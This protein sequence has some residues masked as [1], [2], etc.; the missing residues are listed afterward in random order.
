M[1]KRHFTLLELMAAMVVL[2]IMMGFLFHFITRSQQ[3][4]NASD[5][6]ARIYENA[7]I[8]FDLLGRDLTGA[9]V[10]KDAERTISFWVGDLGTADVQQNKEDFLAFATMSAGGDGSRGANLWEIHYRWGDNSSGVPK[11][12]RCR[13]WRAAVNSSDTTNWD[14]YG[15]DTIHWT[16]TTGNFQAVI[17]GVEN[18]EILCRKADGTDWTPGTQGQELPAAI[19]VKLTL[20][21]EQ[22]IHDLSENVIPAAIATKRLDASRRDFVKAFFLAP[23]G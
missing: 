1:K 23:R 7:R 21:D 5:R 18:I 15:D 22:T 17:D 6:N 2:V 8:F 20:V 14:F 12:D 19:R 9:I 10:S 13:V 16:T 11:S 4:W 3:L